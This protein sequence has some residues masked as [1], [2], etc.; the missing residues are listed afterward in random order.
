MANNEPRLQVIRAADSA[1]RLT[2]TP[3]DGEPI[4]QIDSNQL[5]IG[6]GVTAGGNR[7]TITFNVQPDTFLP[8]VD[9]IPSGTFLGTYSTV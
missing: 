4:Y 1:T 2:Y 9:S 3:A 8:T 6:D 7:A 5:Y